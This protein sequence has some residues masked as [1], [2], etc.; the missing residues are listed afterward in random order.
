[1]AKVWQSDR[2]VYRKITSEDDDFLTIL[3]GNSLDFIQS[4]PFA[5]A[6]TGKKD[7]E[8]VQKRFAEALLGVAICL[9]PDTSNSKDDTEKT[10]GDV[11]KDSAEDGALAHH[12]HGHLGLWISSAYQGNGYGSEA[13]RWALNWAFRMVNLHRVDLSAFEWNTG[14]VKLYE[15][16]GFRI[17]GR[18][19]EHLWYDGRYWDEIE[20]GILQ[21]EWREKYGDAAKD[22]SLGAGKG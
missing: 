7:N 5:P 18:K 17:E 4:A 22:A 11:S 20:M 15:K 2:L 9:Q 21:R 3:H 19:R 16:M 14:A 8:S 10:N 13:I 12:R 6:P 1:M